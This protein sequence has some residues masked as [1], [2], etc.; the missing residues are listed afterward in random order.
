MSARPT[1]Q[2]N[3]D[4]GHEADHE[5]GFSLLETIFAL[6]IMSL[7][8]VALFQSTTSML[9]LSER[10]VAA[11]ERTVSDGLDRLAL[12]NLVDGLVPPWLEE[13]D[14]VFK[15]SSTALQGL[16]TGAL[17]LVQEQAV[18]F[19]LTLEAAAGGGT[20]LVY[21]AKD[22]QGGSEGLSLT[23]HAGVDGWILMNDLPADAR[24]FYMGIDQEWRGVWPP[25]TKPVRGYFDDD[26]YTRDPVLPIAIR[27]SAGGEF[28]IWSG[29]VSR[30]HVLP[31]RYDP[32]QGL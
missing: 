32:I 30:S 11:G 18:L 22:A 24:F 5:S 10:A 6:A 20:A 4:A 27:L 14:A 28:V 15:G 29:T 21:R 2:I 1:E 16:S 25:D 23:K 3:N 12:T 13:K 8:S 7:A 17:T 19:T 26:R 31:A 9:T